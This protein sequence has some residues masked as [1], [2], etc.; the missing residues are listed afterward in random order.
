MGMQVP[1]TSL[2]P[3]IYQ[4]E[5][6]VSDLQ[7]F[8]IGVMFMHKWEYLLLGRA[9]RAMQCI[10]ASALLAIQHH[11][12]GILLDNVTTKLGVVLCKT[13]VYATEYS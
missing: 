13:A 3:C 1:S 9:M 7:S 4:L 12:L 5:M 10:V 11:I 2:H 6:R 8:G